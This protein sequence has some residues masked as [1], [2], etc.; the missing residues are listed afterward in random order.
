MKEKNNDNT[1]TGYRCST[2]TAEANAAA[3]LKGY[4]PTKNL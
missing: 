1:S 4:L 2:S 3:S